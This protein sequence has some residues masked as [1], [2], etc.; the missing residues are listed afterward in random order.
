[1]AGDAGGAPRPPTRP[2][3]AAAAPVF[4]DDGIPQT[5]DTRGTQR[6]GD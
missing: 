4:G 6:G 5:A 1:M 3:A 2:D